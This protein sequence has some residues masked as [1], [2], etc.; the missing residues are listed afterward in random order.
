[1]LEISKEKWTKIQGLPLSAL[2]PALIG[3][4]LDMKANCEIAKNFYQEGV[5]VYKMWMSNN[6]KEVL[7]QFKCKS[8]SEYRVGCNMNGLSV[9]LSK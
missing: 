4:T 3:K 7:M 2:E 6:G 8:G 9:K 5:V 1:M